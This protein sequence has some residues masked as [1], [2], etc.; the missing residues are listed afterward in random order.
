LGYYL[1]LVHPKKIKFQNQISSLIKLEQRQFENG[2][3]RK[4]ILNTKNNKPTLASFYDDNN[5]LYTSKWNYSNSNYLSSIK[6]FA[7]WDIEFRNQYHL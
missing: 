5:Q 7:K 3:N 4:N 6:N 1:S 2:I